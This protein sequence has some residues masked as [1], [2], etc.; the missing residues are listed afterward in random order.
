MFVS[1]G[2][3]SELSCTSLTSDD[4][5]STIPDNNQTNSGTS[6]EQAGG[7]TGESETSLMERISF[8]SQLQQRHLGTLNTRRSSRSPGTE[9]P[10]YE[11]WPRYCQPGQDIREVSMEWPTPSFD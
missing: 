4:V 6:A 3:Q 10:M 1:V 2:D 8:A 9:N 11:E 5:S 7:G